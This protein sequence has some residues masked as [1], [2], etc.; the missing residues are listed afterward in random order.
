MRLFK[1]CHIPKHFTSRRLFRSQQSPP[2]RAM[3]T[4]LALSGLFFSERRDRPIPIIST[5]AKMTCP[6]APDQAQATS[7]AG[8]K[9]SPARADDSSRTIA[10]PLWPS[11]SDLSDQAVSSL[12]QPQRLVFSIHFTTTQGDMSSLFLSARADATCQAVSGQAR[13]TCPSL[14]SLSIATSHV[15]SGLFRPR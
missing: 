15:W 13:V 3:A 11:Q 10:I 8:S 7:H 5:Q 12:A 2:D 4:S 9:T 1:P 14:P 6:S